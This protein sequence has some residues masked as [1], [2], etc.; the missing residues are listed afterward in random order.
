MHASRTRKS[1]QAGAP[2]L[3]GSRSAPA[4]P[5]A[6]P[7]NRARDAAALLKALANADRLL[8]LHCLVG[9][10]RTV[11]ELGAMTAIAQPTLSQP[12]GVLR[13]EGLVATRRECRFI[14]YHIA[15]TAVHAVLRTLHDIFRE[16][17]QAAVH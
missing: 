10:E 13:N 3:P 12:L 15:S 16:N 9:A 6:L 17:G 4:V 5:V 14:R 1:S 2:A 7:Q 8:L 11:A